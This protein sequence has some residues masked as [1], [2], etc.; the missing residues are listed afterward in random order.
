MVRMSDDTMGLLFDF[1]RLK[2]RKIG[3]KVLS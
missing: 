3:F 2:F 1:V